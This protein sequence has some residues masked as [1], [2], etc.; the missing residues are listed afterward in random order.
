MFV[1]QRVLLQ[2]KRL[3]FFLFPSRPDL[4]NGFTMTEGGDCGHSA[5]P[6]L[7]A[8]TA[9]NQTCSLSHTEEN[10]AADSTYYGEGGAGQAS[11]QSHL[12]GAGANQA[13]GRSDEVVG[14]I[15]QTT[16]S[17]QSSQT[18]EPIGGPNNGFWQFVE[19]GGGMSNW[20]PAD[21]TVEQTS[22]RA[23]IAMRVGTEHVSP[24]EH[25]ASENVFRVLYSG[26]GVQQINGL[27][28]NHEVE[29]VAEEVNGLSV[30]RV[31]RAR[32]TSHEMCYLDHGN[33]VSR[34]QYGTAATGEGLPYPIGEEVTCLPVQEQGSDQ[35]GEVNSVSSV[36]NAEKP[37]EHRCNAEEIKQWNQQLTRQVAWHV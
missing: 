7:A 26:E 1:P 4:A 21:M 16:R 3:F 22:G 31:E 14:N 5:V 29:P 17:S 28:G 24:N 15:V 8:E 18:R 12:M 32:Q 11:E 35:P 25:A 36:G 30:H 33:G 37:T 34:C 19:G 23:H 20:R 13:N 6:I 2:S 27:P 9:T 10:A